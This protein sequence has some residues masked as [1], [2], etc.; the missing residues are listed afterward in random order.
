VEEEEEEV[1]RSRSVPAFD[2]ERSA[3]GEIAQA[4]SDLMPINCGGDD[5]GRQIFHSE[6][7]I[8]EV[9][10][11]APAVGSTNPMNSH[12]VLESQQIPET[13]PSQ[14]G[15]VGQMYTE[16]TKNF[17]IQKQVGFSFAEND[18]LVTKKLMEEEA[19]DRA[20]VRA[21]EQSSGDQ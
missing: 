19:K 13:P 14:L 18:D 20:T 11:L 12:K 6:G 5:P 21:R 15:E 7:L 17:N 9:V 3:T 1:G 4:V 2:R 10:L 16:A 8:L